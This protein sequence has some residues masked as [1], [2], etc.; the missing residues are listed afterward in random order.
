MQD[1]IYLLSIEDFPGTE[2]ERGGGVESC[3]S[4]LA[5]AFDKVDCERRKKADHIKSV[6]PRAA[7]LGAGLLMQYAMREAM[8]TGEHTESWRQE[9][10]LA[11]KNGIAAGLTEKGVGSFGKTQEVKSVCDLMC[12]TFP[13]LLGRLNVP[14]ALQYRYG[15]NGKPYLQGDPFY[16]NLSHSGNY[17]ICAVSTRE[18][19][20]DIQQHGAGGM[21]RLAQRFFSADE[22]SALQACGE[23]REA[24]F[25]RLWTRKEAYGKLTGRGIAGALEVNLLPGTE[26]IPEGRKLVWREYGEIKGYSMAICQFLYSERD[27]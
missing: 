26:E 1:R 23:E 8:Y 10:A 12:F 21:E 9:T 13:E 2:K 11:E 25:Y 17:V 7:C 3:E 24:L 4:L 20:A 19:G 22:V 18:I 15:A 16:F 6:R 27:M 14:L 5:E